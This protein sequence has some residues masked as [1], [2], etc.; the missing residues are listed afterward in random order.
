MKTHG[1]FKAFKDSLAEILMHIFN[2]I[3]RNKL[4]NKWGFSSIYKLKKALCIDT[5]YLQS[6]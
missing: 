2:K 4:E 1:I 5:V 3:F 6:R